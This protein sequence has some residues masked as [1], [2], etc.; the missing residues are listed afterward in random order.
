MDEKLPDGA[1]VSGA[2]VTS[3]HP[4]RDGTKSEVG[5]RRDGGEFP[6]E[7]RPSDRGG[8][9]RFVCARVFL[10]FGFRCVRDRDGGLSGRVVG[11]G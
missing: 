3:G 1:N 5:Y 6:R 7:V 10:P 9:D 4:H 2:F 11:R 8:I